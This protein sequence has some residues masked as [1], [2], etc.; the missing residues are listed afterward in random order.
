MSSSISSSK[1][2]ACGVTITIIGIEHR[3]GEGHGKCPMC[4]KDGG[5]EDGD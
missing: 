1:C 2:L 4:G 3:K 5:W